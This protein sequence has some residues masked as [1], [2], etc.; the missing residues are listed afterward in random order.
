MYAP[1][2]R[3][4]VPEAQVTFS[5]SLGDW[6]RK[7]DEQ[8]RFGAD[9]PPGKYPLKIASPQGQLETTVEIAQQTEATPVDRDLRF[10][11]RQDR[12]ILRK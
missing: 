4:V 8:G 3:S 2:G 11:Q 7:T 5:S 9:L 10:P 1:D 6:T 12:F